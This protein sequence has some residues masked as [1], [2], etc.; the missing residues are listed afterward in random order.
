[1]SIDGTHCWIAE[2]SQDKKCYSH[3]YSKTGSSFGIDLACDR[4]FW[5]N[6]PFRA[7]KKDAKNFRTLDHAIEV[8]M[9]L[10]CS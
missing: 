10:Q 5:M 6:G 2:W 4:V 3:R 1:M 9:T 7:G 8:F